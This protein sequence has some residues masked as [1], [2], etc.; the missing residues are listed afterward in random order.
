MPQNITSQELESYR[1]A[2]NVG[3]VAAVGQVYADLYAQGYNYAGWAE[4]VA[5]G[6]SITGLSALHYMDESYYD[7]HGSILSDAWVDKIRVEMALRTLN[8]YI[9][10]ADKEGGGVLSR[11]LKYGETKAIHEDTF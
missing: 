2:I 1:D 7:E 4:G 9:K 10:I 8:E 3:G 5:K 11:D 6:N